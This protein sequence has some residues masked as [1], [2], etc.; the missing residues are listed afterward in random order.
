MGGAVGGSL[1]S[2]IS[3]FV[4]GL[5]VGAIAKNGLKGGAIGLAL[6]AVQTGLESAI[7]EGNNCSCKK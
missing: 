4:K 2:V 6:G 1:G 3:V 5:P 7:R